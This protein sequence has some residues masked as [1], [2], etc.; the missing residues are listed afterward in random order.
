MYFK[1]LL[2]YRQAW[3]GVALLWIIL[4]HWNLETAGL[5][6]HLKSIGYGGA[7]ICLFASGIGCFYS[8]TSES[9]IGN[10][11]KRR[12]KRLMPTYCIFIVFWLAFK[13]VTG[14]FS[15]QMALG[16]IL[17]LQHFSDHTLS[18]NWYISAVLLFYLF[19][20]YFKIII[21]RSSTFS[22]YLFLAF[23]FA[24]SIPFWKVHAHI[25]M[26]SRLPIFYMGMLFAD[27]CQ[28]DKKI[29]SKHIVGA[30]AMFL[31]GLLVLLSSYA[32]APQLMWSHG[33]YWYPFIL[34]APPLCMAISY[35]L[36]RI[37][38]IRILKPIITFLS[39]CGNYSFELYLVHI[40]LLSLIPVFIENYNLSN[41]SDLVWVAGI[42]PLVVGCYLLRSLTSFFNRLYQKTRYHF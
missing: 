5:L 12:L 35:V 31:I 30:T 3:L 39:L 26:V 32:I 15:V 13:F 23:L 6:N 16:N 11:I 40:G 1:D 8:L 22:K 17:A 4:F 21:D 2:R 14:K 37:E 29:L 7:D 10:F 20:P 41:I 19:A 24:C 27:V 36:S 33:L 34:I 42:I 9:D 28:K 25:V 38:R 18:F